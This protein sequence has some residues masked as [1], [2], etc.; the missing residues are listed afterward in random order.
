M[1]IISKEVVVAY[2]KYYSSM[3]LTRL[4]KM[5]SLHSFKELRIAEMKLKDYNGPES[6]IKF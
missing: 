5:C 2:L 1:E 3:C 4:N 6:H